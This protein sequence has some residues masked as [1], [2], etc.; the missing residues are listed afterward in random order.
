MATAFTTAQIVSNMGTSSQEQQWAAG[1]I[2]DS[3]ARSIFFKLMAGNA[4]GRA[5]G[6]EHQRHWYG[7]V[8]SQLS[9]VIGCRAAR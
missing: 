3:L 9:R 4:G 8:S 2:L 5:I 1:T 6:D 7:G